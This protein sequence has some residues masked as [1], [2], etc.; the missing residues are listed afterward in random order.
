[1]RAFI[2]HTFCENQ[3]LVIDT[4][5]D[6]SVI[7]SAT[8][9]IKI[10]LVTVWGRDFFDLNSNG[11]A[12]KLSWTAAVSDDA[13]LA[14]DRNGNGVVDNGQELFGN[15]TPQPTP[16]QGDSVRNFPGASE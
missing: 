9:T 8:Q 2:S 1:M 4:V 11:V 12:E 10:K 16:P 7:I 14:L 6:A 5:A 3:S 15:F 13:W